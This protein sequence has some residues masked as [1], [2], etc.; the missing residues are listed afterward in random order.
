MHRFLVYD[1]QLRWIQCS[2][3]YY[4]STLGY[5]YVNGCIRYKDESI[6]HVREYW[7]KKLNFFSFLIFN[8]QTILFDIHLENLNSAR[9]N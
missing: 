4:F 8:L 2:R 3:P 9:P 7:I 1:S 6:N 5:E